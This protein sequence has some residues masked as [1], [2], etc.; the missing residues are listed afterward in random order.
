MPVI[1]RELASAEIGL[2]TA[3]GTHAVGGVTGL[4]LQVTGSGA[5]SWLLR[6]KVD[7][8]RR[9]FGLGSFPTVA[10]LAAQA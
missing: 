1:A 5:R 7:S 8:K 6:I 10:L 3:P 4:C 9:E 2:I